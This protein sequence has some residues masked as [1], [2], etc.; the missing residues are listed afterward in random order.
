MAHNEMRALLYFPPP[1][2]LRSGPLS[3]SNIKQPTLLTCTHKIL[4]KVTMLS[5][6]ETSSSS[7]SSSA[8]SQPQQDDVLATSGLISPLRGSYSSYYSSSRL[9]QQSRHHRH[10]PSG[11]SLFCQDSYKL[12]KKCATASETECFSCSDAVAQYMRCALNH[13]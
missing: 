11:S 4:P 1:I 3:S 10:Q 2:N 13:C 9:Q 7:S 5:S 12:F 6:R 8:P